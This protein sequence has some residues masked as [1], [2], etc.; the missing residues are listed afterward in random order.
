MHSV[1]LKPLIFKLSSYYLCTVPCLEPSQ[2]CDSVC[3]E[4]LFLKD[5]K[6]GI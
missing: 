2:Q 5:V 4:N 3:S 6:V 1:S